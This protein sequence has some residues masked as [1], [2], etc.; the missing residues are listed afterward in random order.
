MSPNKGLDGVVRVR[1]NSLGA[2]VP[3]SL[4]QAL[5]AQ[6]SGNLLSA[7]LGFSAT[8]LAPTSGSSTVVSGPSC[9]SGN[10]FAGYTEKRV[11]FSMEATPMYAPYPIYDDKYIPDMPLGF[12]FSFQG[13]TYD[14]VNVF[15]NG[16]LQ[17]GQASSSADGFYRGGIIPSATNPNNILAFAWTDWSPQLVPDGIRYETR[18]D[19]PK[20]KFILQYTNVPEYNSGSRVGAIKLGVGRLTA[21]VVLEEG[22][23]DITIYTKAFNLNNSNNRYTQGIENALGTVA[24]FDTI[25]NPN[26]GV[27]TTRV[28]KFFTNI[29]LSDDAVRFS[30][31]STK[32]E[33]APSITAPDNISQGNDLHLASAVVAVGTPVAS[34]NCG[35]VALSSARSDGAA[36]DAPYP[37]GVTT[38]TWTATDA[39]GNKAS[40]TQTVTVLD[41]EPPEFPSSTSRL[42]AQSQSALT[43]NATSP[44]GAVV[45]YQVNA[46]DNVGVIS[47]VC[48]PESGSQF[49]VGNTT[50]TCTA[51]DAARNTASESFDVHVSSAQEQLATLIDVLRGLRLPNGTAQ[52]L[53]NQIKAANGDELSCKKLSDFMDMLVKKQ[54]TI[55][56]LDFGTLAEM[57]NTLSGAMGCTEPGSPAPAPKRFSNALP[58]TIL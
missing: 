31:I 13:N 19:A 11:T 16:F 7:P 24:Q 23:N 58:N 47:L 5:S 29:S 44:S 55:G 15:S 25:I 53:I 4:K 46:T 10:A 20:R 36:I 2:D 1:V 3:D 51:S 41:I 54:S 32:D 57:A 27:W 14:K 43:F 40:A 33:V 18:G 6:A 28:A 8:M 22:S 17:F 56:P 39:A 48:E 45:T 21:Q 38:I 37:V 34:D 12:S 49:P 42:L 50:V 30:L 26:T 9:G 35:D 52:P